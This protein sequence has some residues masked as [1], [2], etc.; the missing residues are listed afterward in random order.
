MARRPKLK[1]RAGKPTNSMRA[2]AG[3]VM[4]IAI[5]LQ[6]FLVLNDREATRVAVNTMVIDIFKDSIALSVAGHF[7]FALQ[8]REGG[9]PPP[10]SDIKQWI[11]DKGLSTGNDKQDESF[12]WGVATNIGKFGTNPPHL[13]DS[14]IN[15]IYNDCWNKFGVRIADAGIE[16]IA[17][18]L[19]TV[20]TKNGFKIV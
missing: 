1:F 15:N 11:I 12:A 13:S 3:L 9:K 5:K 19:D 10:V 18:G 16:V 17:D 20:F 8:G 6:E 2:F 7:V 14:D 4:C